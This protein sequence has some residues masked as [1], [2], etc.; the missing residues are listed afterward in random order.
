MKILIALALATPL[1]AQQQS[2]FRLEQGEFRWIPV[3]VKQIPT[4]IECKFQVVAGGPTAHLELLRMHDFRLFTR[5]REHA[6]LAVSPKSRTGN[7][8]RVI[9]NR[10]QY[11]VV[12]VNEKNAPAVMVSLEVSTE[13]DPNPKLLSRELPPARRLTVI[14]ISFA[15]FFVTITWSGLKLLRAARTP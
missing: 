4:E 10:G 1:L 7:F 12:V 8:R 15:L 14:L 2:P 9:D 11:A 3:I 13:V 5:N 6:T